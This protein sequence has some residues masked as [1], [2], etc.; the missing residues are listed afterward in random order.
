M[1]SMMIANWRTKMQIK[2]KPK[3]G[4]FLLTLLFLSTIPLTA[5]ALEV[6]ICVPNCVADLSPAIF[7][8]GAPS[9]VSG[10]TTTPVT[11]PSTAIPNPIKGFTIVAKVTAQQSGTLQKIVFN[12]TTLTAPSGCTVTAPCPI[13]II[14]TSETSSA[15]VPGTDQ[16]G[17]DF[18]VRKPTGG[19]PAGVFM[20]GAFTGTMAT[21]TGNGDTIS[22]TAE[23]SG[24]SDATPGLA[25]NSDVI[26][27]TPGAGTGDA[28]V[29]LPSGCTGTA[30]CKFTA[31]SLVKSFNSQI[32]ETVQQQC[33]AGLTNCLTRLKTRVDISFKN[34]SA[35]NVHKVTLPAGHVH[36]N[37]KTPENPN[38]P[39]DVLVENT[40]RTFASINWDRLFVHNKEFTLNGRFTLDDNSPGLREDEEVHLL[41]N[42]LDK[43]LNFEL[44]MPSLKIALGG[45]QFTFTGNA[46]GHVG[47][48]D[49]V[50]L[51]VAAQFKR[52]DINPKKWT[53]DATIKGINLKQKVSTT[54]PGNSVLLR[55]VG[56]DGGGDTGQNNVVA[57]IANN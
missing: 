49:D 50:T 27:A 56:G 42:N 25:I 45:A 1:I 19:Y 28:V 16:P 21:G 26:N 46:V 38:N 33:D 48:A 44:I 40:Y 41:I 12:P 3:T 7:G 57:T 32:T 52:D 29:S 34:T 10:V 14:A 15:C 6:K 55:L 51:S 30:T 53:F 43:T 2:M 11:I 47:G 31:T 5:E 22:M 39:I 37:P 23:A 18:P 9:T 8:P 13:Q 20:A 35:T 4:L 24:L 54:L 36:V 17:C